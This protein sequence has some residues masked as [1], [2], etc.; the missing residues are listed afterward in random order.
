MATKKEPKQSI[1]GRLGLDP[2]AKYT[3]SVSQRSKLAKKGQSLKDIKTELT[4]AEITKLAE[5]N[6]VKIDTL[7]IG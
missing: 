3:L 4:G 7:K 6:K 2:K 1:L 5:A